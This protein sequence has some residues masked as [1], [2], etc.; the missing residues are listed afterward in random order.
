MRLNITKTTET[1]L[2]ALVEILSDA[3]QYKIEHKDKS[4]GD[5]PYTK[6]ELD[7]MLTKGG[8][9]TVKY[10]SEIIATFTLQWEDKLVWGEQAH[11]AGY[12][13]RLAVKNDRHGQEIGVQLIDWAA[14]H[15]AKK[16][17][18]CLR[19]DCDAANSRL[20]GYYEK[21]G[22]KQVSTISLYPGQTTALYE[23]KSTRTVY[24]TAS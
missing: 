14:K 1:D 22:F 19:L 7:G 5:E 17:K 12:L 6:K 9:Y 15:A 18:G 4:W 13:H 16:G 24:T 10:E 11:K 21:Q 20:C 2:P 8:L 3:V 23:K